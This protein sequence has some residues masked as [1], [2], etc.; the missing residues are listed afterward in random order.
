MTGMVNVLRACPRHYHIP[1][2]GAIDPHQFFRFFEPPGPPP[3]LEVALK[4]PKTPISRALGAHR[5]PNGA[6]NAFTVQSDLVGK[7][8]AQNGLYNRETP[9]FCLLGLF[10]ASRSRNICP[11]PSAHPRTSKSRIAA[12]GGRTVES[13]CKTKVAE[14][15]CGSNEPPLAPRLPRGAE[16]R[17]IW[18]GGGGYTGAPPPDAKT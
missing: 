6:H 14:A 15:Y 13:G 18:L 3:P 4:T 11:R 12:F 10:W 2:S 1:P 17:P 8:F 9:I 7:R 16:L 5:A